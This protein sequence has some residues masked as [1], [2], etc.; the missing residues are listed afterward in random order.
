MLLGIKDKSLSFDNFS[1]YYQAWK[2]FI[3]LSSKTLVDVELE[4]FLVKVELMVVAKHMERHM[5]VEWAKNWIDVE[6][7]AL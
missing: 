7:T 5:D 3:W 2:G 4:F 1:C 6:L